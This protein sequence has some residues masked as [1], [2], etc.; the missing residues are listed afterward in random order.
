MYNQKKRIYTLLEGG[1]SASGPVEDKRG[2][3]GGTVVWWYVIVWLFE[4]FI[5]TKWRTVLGG[6]TYGSR[7]SV[8]VSAGSSRALRL[9]LINPVDLS[10]SITCTKGVVWCGWIGLDWIKLDW[11]GLGWM[12]LKVKTKGQ[13]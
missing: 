11:V 3:Y 12:L 5:F 1:G 10:T 13:D 2:R 8:S 6:A 9:T 7:T 4:Y